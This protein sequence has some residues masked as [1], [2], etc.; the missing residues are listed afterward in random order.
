MA[1]ICTT[2]TR[3]YHSRAKPS[4]DEC[5]GV[6]YEKTREHLQ[7]SRCSYGLS[8]ADSGVPFVILSACPSSHLLP[9][10]CRRNLLCSRI[11]CRICRE[12][13]RKNRGFLYL[14]WVD[15]WLLRLSVRIRCESILPYHSPCWVMVWSNDFFDLLGTSF[16]LPLKFKN[17]DTASLV[18]LPNV[19][20]FEKV[21]ISVGHRGAEFLFA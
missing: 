1:K 21:C 11:D 2:L 10:F 19:R 3:I 15:A 20:D 14:R 8:N 4:F 7:F 16:R 13:V 9:R 18:S 17:L 6:K 5:E 12:A